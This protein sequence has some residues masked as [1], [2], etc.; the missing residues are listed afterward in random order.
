MSDLT[1]LRAIIKASM[2]TN[3]PW[4]DAAIASAFQKV[5]SEALWFN[6][7]EFTFSTQS[8]VSRYPLPPGFLG[9]RGKV[10]CTPNSSDESG[11]YPLQSYSVDEYEE[12]RYASTEWGGWENS[13][14]PRGFAIDNNGKK[15]MLSPEPDSGGDKIFFRYTI[16]L[17]TPLYTATYS[18]TPT[19][20]LLSP[21]GGTLEGTFTSPWLIHGFNLL[22][23]WALFELWTTYHGGTEQAREYSQAAAARYVEEL[24]RLRGENTQI[25]SVSK[26]RRYL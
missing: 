18:S 26:I 25:A 13:G 16:D 15:M 24:N 4:T 19:V 10:Y 23:D 9:L 2:R 6:G 21:D 20:T 3:S 8:G 14:R 22:K 11:R 5:R 7:S 1:T 12:Y 17:G